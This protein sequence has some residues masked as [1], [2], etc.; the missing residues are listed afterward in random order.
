MKKLYSTLRGCVC[1]VAL[2]LGL[3]ASAEYTDVT[4][5]YLP[6]VDTEFNGPTYTWDKNTP[7]GNIDNNF[8]NGETVTVGGWSIKVPEQN[9]IGIAEYGTS[10]TLKG[11][12]TVPAAGPNGS[13]GGGFVMATGWGTSVLPSAE[14][15]LPAGKYKLISMVY[16]CG[17]KN[18]GTTKF[19]WV[20]DGASAVLSNV[21]YQ[22]KVWQEELV[23][24]TLLK[25]T[26]GK[27]QLGYT[28]VS[29]TGSGAQAKPCYDYVKL[30][31]EEIPADVLPVAP[32]MLVNAS[33]LQ[34]G[35]FWTNATKNGTTVFENNGVTIN[36]NGG[37]NIVCQPVN[38]KRGVSYTFAVNYKG[39]TEGQKHAF[40]G[41]WN[42]NG[43]NAAWPDNTEPYGD[44][45]Y[46][47]DWTTYTKVFAPNEDGTK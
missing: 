9:A 6:G 3:G 38:L 35:E 24:F 23:E 12:G 47:A 37:D 5:T 32:N 8:S 1:A 45:A 22:N 15:T 10:V 40:A 19:G 30:M 28:A 18:G 39:G 25:E 33:F 11:S 2:S 27:I 34:N 7:G 21:A 13:A 41:F 14:V 26:K 4:A 44:L 36:A 42:W 31:R 20:P 29:G 17:D 46:A 43:S 16:N